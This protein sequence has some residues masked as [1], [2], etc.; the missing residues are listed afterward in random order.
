MRHLR[1]ENGEYYSLDQEHDNQETHLT[2]DYVEQI[3]QILENLYDF[4]YL[5]RHPLAQHCATDTRQG[6]E[7]TGQIL[8]RELLSAIE[9][10]NPG[11]DIPFRAPQARLYNCI[12]L[13][14][15]EG[16][17]I[18]EVALE[19]GL[20]TRQV[21]RD[22]K[23]GQ[24][25]VAEVFWARHHKTLVPEVETMTSS[26]ES[27]VRQLHSVF[28]SVDMRLLLQSALGAVESLAVR[29]SVDLRSS[30][31]DTPVMVSTDPTIARQVFIGVLSHTLKKTQTGT[32][33][34]R[35]QRDD[36]GVSLS[37]ICTA[38][39][40]D[41]GET[42]LGSVTQQLLQ[43]LGWTVHLQDITTGKR[44][45]VIELTN[46]YPLILIIDDNEGMVD[47]FNRYLAGH[48]YRTISALQGVD[49]LQL[50]AEMTPNVIVLDVMMPEMDGW[51]V[52]QR[53]H[54]S[55]QTK[56]IPVIIC[57]IF[58]DPDLAYSLDASFLL[59]KPVT[60]ENFLDALK[61]VALKNT[62]P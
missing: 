5:Q 36:S 43:H 29:Q 33:Q 47:L 15:I 60:Q 38:K 7:T 18:R 41:F 17:T 12:Y 32:L 16:L 39:G 27:E 44:E 23:Q 48:P 35:L 51:E 49:G 61:K 14:F 52:L 57:S 24:V 11:S 2:D 9:T 25:S 19:L 37:F 10:L 26:V 6:S 34:A 21:Y 59:P 30:V 20:S 45:I 55:P 53:L 62:V 56:N 40:Q 31:P 13:H 54:T 46:D 28:Q 50:A 58:N 1:P 22:L 3:K 42:P 8:R 4:P